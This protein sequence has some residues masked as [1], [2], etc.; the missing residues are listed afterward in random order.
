MQKKRVNLKRIRLSRNFFLDEYIPQEL[1]EKYHLNKPHYLLGMLDEKLVKIDQ[2]LRDRFGSATINNWITG[3][4]RNWSGVRTTDSPYYSFFSQ[5]SWGR[6][7][8]KIFSDANADEVRKDIKENYEKIYKPLGLTCIED[9]VNWIHSDC[10]NHN[11]AGYFNTGL[12]I[13]TP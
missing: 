6:A 1:Y 3:G 8:D 5:H 10:R 11:F 4:D 7:S 9:K 12:L 2:K 13:V